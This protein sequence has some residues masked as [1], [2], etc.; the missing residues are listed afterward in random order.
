MPSIY[1]FILG[2]II[3]ETPQRA[4]IDRVFEGAR[5]MFSAVFFVSIG[6]QIDIRV[7]D[8]FVVGDGR[9]ASFAERGWI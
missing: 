3:A 2:S 8:H 9:P 4:Q 5:D 6:M 1:I 7:L